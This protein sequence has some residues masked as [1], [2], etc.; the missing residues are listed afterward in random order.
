MSRKKGKTYSSEQ[1]VKIVLELLKE[2]Q[3]VGQ[4]ATQYGVTSK[5]IRNWKKQF[6]DNANRA[7]EDDKVSDK[8]KKQIEIKNKEIDA[9]A[10]TLGKTTVKMEWAVGKLK[11]LNL[12]NKKNL[13]ESKHKNIS[14]NAQCELLSISRSSY[15]YKEKEIA[16]DDI[17]VMHKIG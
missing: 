15:Y 13:I 10:K 9:L 3:T 8:Y 16:K 17:K 5:T 1:K 6:L 14:V 7:F 11:S 2:E 4:L 12:I